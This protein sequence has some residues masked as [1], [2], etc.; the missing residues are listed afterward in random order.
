ML[1]THKTQANQGDNMRDWNNTDECG[2]CYRLVLLC[3]DDSV[4]RDPKSRGGMKRALSYP[5]TQAKG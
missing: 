3:G 5:H 1:I 4:G 2:Y